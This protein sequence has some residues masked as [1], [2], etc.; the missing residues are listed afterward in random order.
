LRADIQDLEVQH[1]MEANYSVTEMD[2]FEVHLAHVIY[3]TKCKSCED[4]AENIG[5]GVV[6]K[7]IDGTETVISV[8]NEIKP[9]LM[10]DW[11]G[12]D[13]K[14][15]CVKGGGM[16]GG[17][18]FAIVFFVSLFAAGLAFHLGRKHGKDTFGGSAARGG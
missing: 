6:S 14:E 18:V 3:L 8:F 4:E 13:H 9:K 7:G 1:L 15:A 2:P 5:V 11:G 12:D 10:G 17:G 16:N